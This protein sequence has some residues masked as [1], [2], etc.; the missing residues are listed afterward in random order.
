LY[1]REMAKYLSKKTSGIDDA[2]E[3]RRHKKKE[4]KQKK[5]YSWTPSGEEKKRGRGAPEFGQPEKMGKKRVRGGQR[6]LLGERKG[7]LYRGLSPNQRKKRDDRGSYARGGE[8]LLHQEKPKKGRF[9]KERG[10]RRSIRERGRKESKERE[11]GTAR[12]CLKN[13]A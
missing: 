5:R 12:H 11:K 4:K 10:A 8:S 7:W 6:K 1:R 13:L 9:M 3:K 2:R